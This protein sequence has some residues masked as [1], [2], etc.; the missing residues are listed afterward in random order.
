M[1]EIEVAVGLVLCGSSIISF[2]ILKVLFKRKRGE[3]KRLD[4]FYSY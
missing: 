4:L 2:E 1:S 3:Y